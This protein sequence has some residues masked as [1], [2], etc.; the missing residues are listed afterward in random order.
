MTTIDAAR[1][2]RLVAAGCAAVLA[3]AIA[4]GPAR[5]VAA[6]DPPTGNITVEVVAINGSGCPVN[7]TNAATVREAPDNTGFHISYSSFRV[8]AGPTNGVARKNCL[9][10][11]QVNVPQGFTLAV[12]RADYRGRV[13]LADG[14]TA[15]HSTNYY[16]QGR[17]ENNVVEQHFAGPLGSGKVGATWSSTDAAA[18][19]VFSPCGKSVILNVNTALQVSSPAAGSWISLRSSDADVDT[20]FQ[21]SWKRC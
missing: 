8:Q 21:F 7:T 3:A 9:A 4:S 13:V 11:V 6:D 2:V 12:A 1:A 10:S 5:A 14:A 17:S 19:V 20:L 18:V 15:V 16:F